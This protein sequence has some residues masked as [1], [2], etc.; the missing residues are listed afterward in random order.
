MKHLASHVCV[1]LVSLYALGVNAQRRELRWGLIAK[2]EFNRYNAMGVTGGMQQVYAKKVQPAIGLYSAMDLGRHVFLDASV[3]L[4]RA[5]YAPNYMQDQVVFTDADI[6]FTEANININLVLNPRS[7][8]ANVFVFGG[9]QSLYRRWGEERYINGI[10][11]NSY[12][13]AVRNMLQAGL[14]VKCH[15]GNDFYL[16]PFLGI[17]YA[18]APQL[19][20]DVR[21]NQVYFGLVLMKGA[22]WHHRHRNRYS[23]CPAAF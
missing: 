21:V 15:A 13:Q 4:S 22:E 1:A 16:Q 19:V 14:G 7:D 17:R 18:G 3:A 9:I 23:G 11:A 10:I 12:W 20:Y 8:K 2:A 6:R 5:R